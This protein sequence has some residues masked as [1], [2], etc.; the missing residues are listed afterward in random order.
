MNMDVS[1][2]ALVLHAALKTELNESGGELLIMKRK[3]AKI[4]HILSNLVSD[5][6]TSKSQVI[7]RIEDG[8]QPLSSCGY[9]SNQ[10]EL[11]PVTSSM[12]LLAWKFILPGPISLF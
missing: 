3:C 2:S 7:G 6:L 12:R 5:I 10:A 9:L 1:I 11:E 8:G 4:C